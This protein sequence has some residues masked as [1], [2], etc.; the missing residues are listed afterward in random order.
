LTSTNV[1]NA[2]FV[3]PA[4]FAQQRLWFLNSLAPGNPFYNIS[5]AIRSTGHLNI[6]VL[7]QT[8]N[9]IVRRHEVLRT[10][11]EMAEGQLNQVIVEDVTLSLS[12]VDLGY[13]PATEREAAAR[14]QAIAKSQYPFDLTA[15]ILLRVTVF[16]LDPTDHI[17][18]LNLHHI[19]ADGWSIGIL[20]R[21][22]IT[23][24]AAF[25]FGKPSPLPELPIQYADFAHWQREWLQEEVLQSQLSYW[26]SQLANL[27]ILNLPTDRTRPAVQTYRGA[28]HSLEVS[29]SLTAS[30]EA[31][32]QEAGV[33]LFMTLLAAFQT[34]LHRYTGQADI[35]VGS[36]IANRNRVELESLIGF[37][38][39][40]LV[41]RT[42]LS[43]NPTF[44]ELLERVREVTLGAYAHQDL[45]FEKLVQFLH[46]ERDL[47]RHPLFSVVIALQNTPITALELPG[48]ALSQ[49]DFDSATSRLDLELH[50]WQT[51]AGLKGQV[52]YSTDLFDSS[53]IT[54]MLGHFQTLLAGIV[55]DP[56]QRLMKLP[57]LTAAERQQLLVEW[58]NT[59]KDCSCNQCIHQLFESQVN[60][61]PEAIA[62]VYQEEQLTYKELNARSNQLAHYL[63][64]LGVTPEVKVGI[65]VER[66]LLMVVGILAILKAGG[67]YVPLDPIYPP[68]RLKFILEDAQVS[69]LLTQE[70]LAPLLTQQSLV[71]LFEGGWGD[72]QLIYL[73]CDS[74]ALLPSAD[75]V[76]AQESQENTISNVTEANLAY[77]IYTSGSTGQ[78]KGVLIEHRGLSNLVQAQIQIF[79]LKPEHRILQFASLSFDA[80]IFEIVMALGIGATLY[81]VPEE[82]RFGA[83]LSSYLRQH[84]IT[85]A[86]LPPAVLKTLPATELPVQTLIS[87]GEACSPEIVARWA[88]VRHFFNAYGLTE[89]TVWSTVAQLN[90]SSSTSIG[91]AIANTQI[92]VLDAHLQ[93][94]AIGISG[95]LYIG[96]VG[97]ARGYLNRPE[98]TAARFIPNPFKENNCLSPASRLYKTGD[99]VCYLPD[100]NLQ[101]LSRLD[102]QVKIRGYRIELAEIESLLSQHP[103]VQE[104]VVIATE[105]IPDN[106]QLIA[107]VVFNAD[108][109]RQ[110]LNC[111]AFWR[112]NYQTT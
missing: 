81:I 55:A 73:D 29:K 30:L 75:R 12:V 34:L 6:T 38:V 21:E 64:K 107:Y 56:D 32:S 37:F 74:E 110:R 67:A 20:I 7:E 33:T 57:I 45:P 35:V 49:F 103:A 22:I 77:V 78:P 41:L 71:P 4:S 82:E 96:G 90:N 36:P 88:G 19:I 25:N 39:N 5:A 69:I 28:T 44:R 52:I 2:E 97:L 102:D 13:L 40:S 3:F 61:T 93:P 91:R 50:L 10:I 109:T 60:K 15:D 27:P 100:G 99:L 1:S 83:A 11:F 68:E 23:L 70:S 106:K 18:L 112:K 108:L 95:E 31:L 101:F 53:T 66:S 54:R 58:N 62:L 24:Y 51:P 43:G 63:Q 8:F 76:I 59:E 80:S 65:C 72:Q 84:V 87:A 89:T 26:R 105:D 104:A 86:T 42:D 17:L 48:L 94:V 9:E 47:S 85:H 79:A 16:Q 92:Y 111:A 14:Q 98:L 46:P